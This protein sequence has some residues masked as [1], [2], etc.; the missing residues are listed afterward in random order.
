VG[1][2]G[3]VLLA[4]ISDKDS[5]L[6]EAVEVLD[7]EQLVSDPRAV[8]LDSGFCQGLPGSM[9]LVPVPAKR[10]QS[11]GIGGELGTVV[12]VDEVGCAPRSHQVLEGGHGVIGVDGVGDEVA[13]DSRVN[14]SLTWRSLTVLPKLVTSKW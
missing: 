10:H 12:A 9:W 4:P 5:G 7:A 2:V 8:G 1:T 13:S 3:V 6:E 14:S 11:K